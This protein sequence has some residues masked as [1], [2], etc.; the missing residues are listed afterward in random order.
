MGWSGGGT[1]EK[2]EGRGD[3][4]VHSSAIH[5]LLLSCAAPRSHATVRWL[6]HVTALSIPS[7]APCVTV[8]V[9]F[10]TRFAGKRGSRRQRARPG[11]L[12]RRRVA[13]VGCKKLCAHNWAKGERVAPAF[14]FAS[15]DL[16]RGP[17]MWRR[18]K[19][20]LK[21]FW[22]SNLRSTVKVIESCGGSH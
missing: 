4:S 8:G 19:V 11:H 12:N 20:L 3:V 14:M 2:K 22:R 1:P 9:P 15:K 21:L 10:S 13:E 16:V 17:R 7:E 18:R 6:A 5:S